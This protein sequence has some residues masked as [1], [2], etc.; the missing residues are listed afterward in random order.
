MRLK[1]DYVQGLEKL[2]EGVYLIYVFGFNIQTDLIKSVGGGL[3]QGLFGMFSLSLSDGECVSLESRK[4]MNPICKFT[5]K[6]ICL[7]ILFVM[8]IFENWFIQGV[9]FCINIWYKQFI[10]EFISQMGGH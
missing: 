3:V 2:P 7:S 6:I 5:G 8:G 1:K 10:L 4:I 9:Y